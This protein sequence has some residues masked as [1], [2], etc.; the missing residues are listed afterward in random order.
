M[1]QLA[2]WLGARRG[3]ARLLD[4]AERI[5]RSRLL[6]G[7]TSER[8][9]A[10]YPGVAAKNVGGWGAH[11]HPHGAKGVIL[12]VTAAVVHTLVDLYQ[13]AVEHTDAGCFVNLHLD[14]DDD[15][16]SVRVT[17]EEARASLVLTANRPIDL[18]V[19]VPRWTQ[20]ASVEVSLDG[21]RIEP[22]LIGAFV[23]LAATQIGGGTRAVMRY[24]LPARETSEVFPSGRRF[25]FTWRGDQI[26]AMQPAPERLPFYG[27]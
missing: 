19:R 11:A 9:A 8:D 16:L 23:H 21:R 12:D 25:S 1:A 18:F 5:L 4:D 20:P 2:L 22:R 7:Q 6:P 15:A 13:H 27:G 10:D 3:D 14:R 24:G 17:R 26:V